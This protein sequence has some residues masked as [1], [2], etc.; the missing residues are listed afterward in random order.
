M[1]HRCIRRSM[2]RARDL[3]GARDP[4][5][6]ASDDSE[7]EIGSGSGPAW[8]RS[9]ARRDFSLIA[10]L[11]RAKRGALAGFGSARG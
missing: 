7:R 8:P 11:G 1:I 10:K 5:D 2:S 3:C 6:D 9:L 4:R